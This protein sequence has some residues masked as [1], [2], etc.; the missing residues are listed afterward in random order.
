MDQASRGDAALAASNF[1]EAIKQYN[2]AI[3]VNNRAAPYYIKRS[4]AHHR[5]HKYAEALT[6]AEVAVILASSRMKRELIKDAQLRRALALFSL[7][8]YADAEFVLDIV[9]KLDPKEKTIPIW[10]M[11]VKKKL[12]E[13][14]EGDE[15][16]KRTAEE[17]PDVELPAKNVPANKEP[18]KGT[19]E[20]AD[21]EPKETT[22]ASPAQ[23]STPTP[24]NKVRHEFY[25]T[26]DNVVI[27]IFAKGVPKD[28]LTV[29][30][31]KQSLEISF[32]TVSNTDFDFTLEPLFAEVD[33]SASS[34]RVTPTKIEVTLKKAVRG[35]RWKVL[36]GERAVDA[37]VQETSIPSHVLTSRANEQAPSYPTS[38]KKGVKN[39]DKVAQGEGNNDDDDDEGGDAAA[40][41]FKTLYSGATPEQQRAM[42]KSYQESGGTVLST[43]WS[44]V[45]SKTVNP[46]PPE[47]MEA[48]K[49]GA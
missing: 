8:R 9:K 25:D 17:V 22:P 48:K 43:D 1:E 29:T 39:W 3:T 45:G 6:D 21:T 4:T 2:A 36:E 33:P 49:W 24:A 38:S 44:Q 31:E 30:I 27:S 15:R 28:K 18:E 20:K 41:F 19:T 26:N 7:G 23:S 47:G 13:L 12:Q 14:D 5:L 16:K 32:P 11:K 34:Y 46:E 37:S 35:Q 42:M 10:E 40:K